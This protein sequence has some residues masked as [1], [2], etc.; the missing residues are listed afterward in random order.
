MKP[1]DS[2]FNTKR[3]PKSTKLANLSNTK[4]L[5]LKQ[6]PYGLEFKDFFFYISNF[7]IIN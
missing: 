2:I 6:K 3:R 5:T 1:V 7:I 4:S